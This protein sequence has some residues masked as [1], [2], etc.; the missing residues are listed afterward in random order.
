MI[1]KVEWGMVA[2][3]VIAGVILLYVREKWFR[4]VK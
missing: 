1:G 4:S 2:G 3:V